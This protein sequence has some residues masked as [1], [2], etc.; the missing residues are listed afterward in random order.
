MPDAELTPCLVSELAAFNSGYAAFWC[1]HMKADQLQKC[2]T[3]C[4]FLT[5]SVADDQQGKLMTWT[6]HYRNTCIRSSC[7]CIPSAVRPSWQLLRKVQIAD[8]NVWDCLAGR[9][10]VIVY[11]RSSGSGIKACPWIET[12]C[13]L[14][15]IS[16]I[17]VK[18]STLQS[19]LIVATSYSLNTGVSMQM[20][21]EPAEAAAESKVPQTSAE[22]AAM[23][24]C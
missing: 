12:V 16:D 8:C 24:D 15:G 3:L 4:V 19:S 22:A 13:T 9:A 5:G 20:S 10:L 11:P 14:A 18:V 6:S 1:L 17:G 23:P 21:S 2:C 7:F